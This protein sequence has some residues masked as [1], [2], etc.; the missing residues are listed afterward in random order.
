M[1][2]FPLVAVTTFSV[3]EE[4]NSSGMVLHPKASVK[5]VHAGV[6]VTEVSPPPPF[7]PGHGICSSICPR[8]QL[9]VTMGYHLAHFTNRI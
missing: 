7:N 4:N 8:M 5:P 1:L 3:L 9:A 2:L 6:M